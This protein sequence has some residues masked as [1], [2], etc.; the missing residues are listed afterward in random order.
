MLEVYKACFELNLKL[1]QGLVTSL[2][3]LSACLLCTWPNGGNDADW[4]RKA[5][6]SS[7]SLLNMT[8][9][10][11][12]LC[13]VLAA[14]ARTP[15]TVQSPTHILTFQQRHD[16]LTPAALQR[17][18]LDPSARCP[19]APPYSVGSGDGSGWPLRTVLPR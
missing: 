16:M 12:R 10:S 1:T 19:A 15:S 17:S 14:G 13:I 8:F 11:G 4:Q 9:V 2:A 3:K 7:A 6:T 18:G 5:L